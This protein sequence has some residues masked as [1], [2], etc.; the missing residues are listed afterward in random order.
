M[1]LK[2]INNSLFFIIIILNIVLFFGNK[3]QLDSS[4]TRDVHNF[5]ETYE[6]PQWPKA[7]EEY[8]GGQTY[9]DSTLQKI[10]EFPSVSDYSLSF[11]GLAHYDDNGKIYSIRLFKIGYNPELAIHTNNDLYIKMWNES[12]KSLEISAKRWKIKKEYAKKSGV[13]EFVYHYKDCFC[14][15]NYGIFIEN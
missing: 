5:F 1:K 10:I 12:Q 7:I 9:Y 2:F 8:Y 14:P 6:K 11:Y 4:S 3:I 15:T 13:F